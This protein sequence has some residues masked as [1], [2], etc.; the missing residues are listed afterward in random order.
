MKLP[1]AP[2]LVLLAI[3]A[4]TLLALCA[5]PRLAAVVALC[6]SGTAAICAVMRGARLPPSAFDEGA[7]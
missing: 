4:A 2:F 1:A 5:S 6:G 7:E 3:L